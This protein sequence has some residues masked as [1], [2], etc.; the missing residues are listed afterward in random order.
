MYKA[1]QN[2][3]RALMNFLL[4]LVVQ[5][6]GDQANKNSIDFQIAHFGHVAYTKYKGISKNIEYQSEHSL[7][8]IYVM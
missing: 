7:G 5:W 4:L 1:V 3:V 6:F 8:I 2:D